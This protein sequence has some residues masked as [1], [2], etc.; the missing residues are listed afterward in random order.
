MDAER[1]E[2]YRK[3]QPLITWR[4]ESIGYRVVC[5]KNDVIRIPPVYD[6]EHP[7]RSL[8]GMVDWCSIELRSLY[9]GNA[10]IFGKDYSNIFPKIRKIDYEVPLDIALLKAI[11]W[12]VENYGFMELKKM[13][14]LLLY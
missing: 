10:S 12:R 13:R 14:Q 4:R 3:I 8:W 11:I 9:E 5:I 6:P 1:L 7:E 2:L